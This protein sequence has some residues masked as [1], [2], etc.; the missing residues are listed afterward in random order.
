MK[1]LTLL[2][3]LF[4]ICFSMTGCG[5]E[6]E[7]KAA[8]AE[9]AAYQAPPNSKVFDVSGMTCG[10]CSSE[11]RKSLSTVEGVELSYVDLQFGKVA[12]TGSADSLE[13]EKAIKAAG[14]E[15]TKRP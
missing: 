1:L 13:V 11:I 7:E 9:K 4:L 12:Y 10:H 14:Y 8:P 6:A 2:I 15:V 3:P 5:K